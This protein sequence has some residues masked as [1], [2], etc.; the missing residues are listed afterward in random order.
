MLEMLI[1]C[2]NFAAENEQC[3]RIKFVLYN[4]PYLSHRLWRTINKSINTL[5]I[6]KGL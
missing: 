6:I 1:K 3:V 5:L 2:I 4:K